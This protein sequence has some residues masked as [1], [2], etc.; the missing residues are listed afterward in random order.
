MLIPTNLKK[1]VFSTYTKNWGQYKIMKDTIAPKINISKAIEG[2]WITNQK[3]LQFTI[4]DELSGIKDYN[5]YINGKWIL[6]EYDF[7]SKKIIHH[8]DDG[9]FDDGKND[10]KL[11][12]SDN[13]GNSTIFETQFFRKK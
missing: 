6:F 10:L 12:V 1:N 7:K 4:S 11:I 8:F 9:I 13:V 2:K 5:G 3:T